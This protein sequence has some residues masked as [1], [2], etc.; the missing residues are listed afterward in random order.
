MVNGLIK[1]LSN[2]VVISSKEI[3]I[4]RQGSYK[5]QNFRFYAL[6]DFLVVFFLRN[7][8]FHTLKL[9][10]NIRGCILQL[11]KKLKDIKFKYYPSNN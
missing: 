8:A 9:I 1:M 3:I 7:I 10:V 11:L 5:E 6:V 2:F 4:F